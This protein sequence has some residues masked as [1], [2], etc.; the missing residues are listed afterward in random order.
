MARPIDIEPK[1][2]TCA[3]VEQVSPSSSR[4]VVSFSAPAKWAF[5]SVHIK[6]VIVHIGK[7]HIFEPAKVSCTQDY[8]AQPNARHNSPLL[9]F[10][11]VR[12]HEV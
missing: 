10:C 5:V 6:V 7:S 8:L 1:H 12:G 11:L 2:E 3:T 9:D 4:E